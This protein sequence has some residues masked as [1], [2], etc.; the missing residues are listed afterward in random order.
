MKESQF[1]LVGHYFLFSLASIIYSFLP[2]FLDP[3]FTLPVAKKRDY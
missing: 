2:Y 1:I 3:F